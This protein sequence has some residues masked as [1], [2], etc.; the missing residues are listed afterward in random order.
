M[1]QMDIG[2][3]T[4]NAA[5]GKRPRSVERTISTN[6]APIW[7]PGCPSGITDEIDQHRDFAPAESRRK[8][9]RCER[10]GEIL[11]RGAD[12]PYIQLGGSARDT[13]TQI[14][15]SHLCGHGH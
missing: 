10:R 1:A 5:G 2:G 14:F 13:V 4:N 7:Q 6:D 9:S 12:L 3:N 11:Q 8:R 15:E